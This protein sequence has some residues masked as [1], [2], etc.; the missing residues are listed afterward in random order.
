MNQKSSPSP[1]LLDAARRLLASEISASQYWGEN[2]LAVPGV[3]E[4]IRRQISALAGAT[5]FK[6]LLSR[7]LTLAKAQM[8]SLSK[9]QVVSDGSLEG[10]GLLDRNEAEEAG[11]I[12]LAQLLGLLVAFLG[13]HLTFQL[14]FDTDP[15]LPASV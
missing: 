10:F 14:V 9:V 12:L 5:G 6:A 8:N 13:E 4:E 11:V 15:D 2:T 7:A 3:I 1:L